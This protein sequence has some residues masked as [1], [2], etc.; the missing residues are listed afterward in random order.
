MSGVGDLIWPQQAALFLGV[1]VTGSGYRETCL[2]PSDRDH[3]EGYVRRRVGA[4]AYIFFSSPFCTRV[5]QEQVN[6]TGLRSFFYSMYKDVH[7]CKESSS[8]DLLAS[9]LQL[10][11]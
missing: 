11:E 7:E 5:L 9:V 1:N 8:N 3:M 10:S 2:L 6:A 4:S